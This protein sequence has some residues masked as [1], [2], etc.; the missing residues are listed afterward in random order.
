VAG[1]IIPPWHFTEGLITKN[2]TVRF[3]TQKNAKSYLCGR[4]IN[5]KML[6]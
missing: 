3:R 1:K 5:S 2:C 4:C 6:R